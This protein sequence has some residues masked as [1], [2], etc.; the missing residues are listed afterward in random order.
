MVDQPGCR[1]K[2]WKVS[3][4]AY[5]VSALVFW[6]NTIAWFNIYKKLLVQFQPNLWMLIMKIKK[7]SLCVPYFT[8]HNIKSTSI[9]FL[10]GNWPRPPPCPPLSFLSELFLL[11]YIFKA[12]RKHLLLQTFPSWWNHCCKLRN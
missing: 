9:I 10:Q 5:S 1:K 6:L 12:W 2:C 3:S 4:G 7:N 8:P 11:V